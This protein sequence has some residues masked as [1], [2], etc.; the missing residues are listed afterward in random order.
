MNFFKPSVLSKIKK[1]EIG[2][3]VFKNFLDLNFLKELHLIQK[4]E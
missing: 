4:K 3:K 1:E 2:V